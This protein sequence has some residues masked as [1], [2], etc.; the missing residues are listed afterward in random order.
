MQDVKLKSSVRKL[1]GKKLKDLRQ[2]GLVPGVVYGQGKPSM[3][4]EVTEKEL[5]S[6]YTRAGTSKLV[7]LDIAG[8]KAKNVLFHEVQIDPISRRIKHFDLYNVRMDEK[9]KTE[10]PLNF[11]GEAPAEHQLQALI[12]KPLEAIE[13]E[14]LPKDLP[15]NIEVDI[16]ILDEID[17]SI[18]VG[19]LKI[20]E[21]VQVITDKDEL[22][23]KVEPPREEEEEPEEEISEEEAVAA[24]GAEHGAEQVDE[25]DTKVSADSK[26]ANGAKEETAPKEGAQKPTEEAPAK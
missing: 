14:A 24:V 7:E 4:I 18:T 2:K 15:E 20:P 21:G 17:K 22:V 26:E 16:S 6:A 23:A 13:I 12:L 11:V 25:G 9:I 10:V 5:Q 3:P 19:D 8:E 1:A